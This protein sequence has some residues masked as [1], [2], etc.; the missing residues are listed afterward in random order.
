MSFECMQLTCPSIDGKHNRTFGILWKSDLNCIFCD[1]YLAC[2]TSMNDVRLVFIFGKS[3]SKSHWK[4]LRTAAWSVEDCRTSSILMSVLE[5]AWPK[6]K[7][8]LTTPF[9]YCRFELVGVGLGSI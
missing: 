3:Q 4:A 1:S 7:V 6:A 9:G 2:M 8:C 5:R